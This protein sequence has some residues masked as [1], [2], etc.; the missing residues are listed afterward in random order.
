MNKSIRLERAQNISRKSVGSLDL[1]SY[2]MELAYFG[3]LIYMMVIGPGL[4]LLIPIAGAGSL[5]VL[6]VLCLMHFGSYSIGALRPIRMALACGISL[7]L[8][9][10]VFFQESIL[11]PWLRNFITWVLGLIVMQC[12]S[13][14]KGFF[15]RF[16]LVAFIIGCGT[17]PFLKVYVVSD[18]M[19]RVGGEGVPL[20]NP[21]F[22]GMW[23][24]FC[25]IYF[26]VT[27]LEAKNYMIRTF[28][29]SSGLLCLYLV[30]MTVSRGALLGVAVATV[31]AFQKILKRSFLPILGFL[32]LLSLVYMSGIFD[33][34]IGYYLHRGTEET[35]RS[36]LWEWAIDG[37]LGSWG[38][39]VGISNAFFIVDDTTGETAGP[40]NSFLFI[41]LSSGFIP[42][43]F[44]I[45]YLVQATRGAFRARTQNSVDSPYM[46]PMVSFALLAVMVADTTFMSAWHMIVF[47]MALATPQ[48][49][50]SSTRRN[51]GNTR[52]FEALKA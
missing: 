10:V 23:F 25:V 22:F 31:I 1:P 6:T 49:D 38:L 17:L 2:L 32:V 16:A 36:R 52:K 44:Y 47:S 37:I 20:G 18:E 29:W 11:H 42:L 33:E 40:H 21:N 48:V 14:R 46:L 41:L 13:F 39:G 45:G 50:R 9:Q 3:L 43:I 34:Q 51:L 4:G 15:H 24:G 30:A 19:S 26:V 35:G 28:S 5:M 12:L 7:L 27:G 8:V